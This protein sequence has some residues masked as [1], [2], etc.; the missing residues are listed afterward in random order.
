MQGRNQS[1][2]LRPLDPIEGISPLGAQSCR[3]IPVLAKVA[4]MFSNLLGASRTTANLSSIVLEAF[5]S[6]TDLTQ[7]THPTV[8]GA[9]SL[10][11]DAAAL[12]LGFD[13]LPKRMATG[14]ICGSPSHTLGRNR[15]LSRSSVIIGLS[16]NG[17]TTRHG[18]PVST[19]A[20]KRSLPAQVRGVVF[21]AAKVS[22]F[23]SRT[24]FSDVVR[25]G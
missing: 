21:A 2:E 15:P 17:T 11:V 14:T 20:K 16:D 5:I 25:V 6:A 7:T 9:A 4:R 18:M 24:I 8:A 3:S 19:L 1:D 13:S 22:M 10:A 23:K 12:K